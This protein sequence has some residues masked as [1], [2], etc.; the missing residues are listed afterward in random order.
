M[1]GLRLSPANRV[2]RIL[3]LGAHSDDIEIGCAGTLLQ[4][5]RGHR[6]VQVTWVVLSAMGP[7]AVEARRSARDLLRS[8]AQQKVILSEFEDGHFPAQFREIKAF[9]ERLKTTTSP[10]IVLTH[11]LDDRHQDHRIVGECTWQ[12]WRNHL[13]LEYEI[14]KF[15]GD[16]GQPNLFV[17]LSRTLANRKIRHLTRH[18]GTQR[19]KSWFRPETFA[20]LMQVRGIEC[21]AASGFSEAFYARKACF[22]TTHP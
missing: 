21:R 18:F 15:D 4:W 9:F 7:R 19:S 11:R 17:P 13:I 22:E 20:S 12:T 10:D 3:C 5:L 6:Q 1:I 14:P 16:L 2:L 8:A